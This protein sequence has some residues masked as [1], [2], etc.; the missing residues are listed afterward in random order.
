MVKVLRNLL[1]ER[2]GVWSIELHVSYAASE[3]WFG[4]LA[5]T[6]PRAAKKPDHGVL[7]FSNSRVVPIKPVTIPRL[8]V[9]VAVLEVLAG[10]AVKRV[11]SN[12]F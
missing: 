11:L 3:G 8:E 6:Q 7:L 5:Y 9:S 1:G 2:D 4:T 10:D 12:A